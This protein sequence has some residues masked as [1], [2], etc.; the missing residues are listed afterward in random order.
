M[1]VAFLSEAG[2]VTGIFKVDHVRDAASSAAMNAGVSLTDILNLADWSQDSSLR[3]QL[4]KVHEG[5][6]NLQIILLWDDYSEV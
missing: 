2:V 5:S 6:S 4:A 1:T 3:S